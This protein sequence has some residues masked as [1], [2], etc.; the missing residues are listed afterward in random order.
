MGEKKAQQARDKARRKRWAKE[1]K[2]Q[3]EK[4][5]DV[6]VVIPKPK[7]PPIRVHP[8]LEFLGKRKCEYLFSQSLSRTSFYQ[9]T[10]Y[11]VDQQGAWINDIK[12]WQP[13]T[14]NVLRAFKSL[15]T[16]LMAKYDTHGWLYNLYDAPFYHKKMELFP[17]VAQGGNIGKFFDNQPGWPNLT[18]KQQHILLNTPF[19][20]LT[21]ERATRRAQILGLGGSQR[22][23]GAVANS[24]LGD[25]FYGVGQENFWSTV[26][27][28]FVQNPV[29]P[30]QV[31]PLLDYIR[32]KKQEQP[33]YSMKGRGATR[34]FLDMEEWHRD[35]AKMKALKDAGFYQTSGL[36]PTLQEVI[37]NGT[38]TKWAVV[39]LLSLKELIKEGRALSH[40]VA[41]YGS[42]IAD[43][44]VSIWSL[45]KGANFKTAE[46]GRATDP[47][48]SIE[49]RGKEIVQ[50]RGFANRIPNVEE[51]RALDYFA[52]QNNLLITRC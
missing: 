16:H 46:D 10:Q 52:Q 49:V 42:M 6:A 29:V 24:F 50:A 34:L 9:A 7:P 26:L 21:L 3:A 40:C 41:A 11:L 43:G 17:H 14:F 19:A 20:S 28:W 15:A 18:K 1:E 30:E 22:L 38:E 33:D 32:F 31:A 25:G 4:A 12:D 37:I 23:A 36:K 27:L 5:K 44:R 47:F 13:K 39:E 51:R 45:R 8:A 2:L 48:L 35:L